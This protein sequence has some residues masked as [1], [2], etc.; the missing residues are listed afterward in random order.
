MKANSLCKHC[1]GK[2]T[3]FKEGHNLNDIYA[4]RKNSLTRLIEDQSP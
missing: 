1:S 3:G 2:I 4:K